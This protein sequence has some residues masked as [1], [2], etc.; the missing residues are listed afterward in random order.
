MSNIPSSLVG[1]PL[2]VVEHPVLR[3]FLELLKTIDKNDPTPT[4]LQALRDMLRAYPDL[5]RV[6]GDLAQAAARNVVAKLGA[7]PLIAESLKCAWTAMQ[8][9]LGYRDAPLLERLVIEQVALSWLHLYIIEL[10]YTNV[11][12]E[13]IPL[14]SADHWERRLSAA[15]RRHLA[16]CESLARLRKLATV[17]SAALQVNIAAHGGQQV[18]LLGPEPSA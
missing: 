18:N 9:E 6:A 1:R 17:G 10:E 16:A 7:H 11:M 13:P 5:W 15:Q 8:D 4:D 12:G 14:A 2:S 3:R